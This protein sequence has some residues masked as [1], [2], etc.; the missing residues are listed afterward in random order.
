MAQV[1]DGAGGYSG[2]DWW[3]STVPEMWAALEREEVTDS[4]HQVQSGWQATYN[5]IANHLERVKDYKTKL[6][7]AWPPEKSPA[8]AAYVERLDALI[9][10]L[11]DTY[12]AATTNHDAFKNAMLAVSSRRDELKRLYEEYAA[13]EAKIAEFTA[14]KERLGNTGAADAMQ[15]EVTPRHQQQLQYRAARIMVGLTSELSEANSILTRPKPYMPNAARNEGAEIGDGTGYFVP[16]FAAGGDHA[17]S[18]TSAAEAHPR[19]SSLE[20][21]DRPPFSR[22]HP[23]VV[24]E[25]ATTHPVAP[26]PTPTSQPSVSPTPGGGFGPGAPPG[27]GLGPQGRPP[28]DPG[29]MPAPGSTAPLGRRPTSTAAN[30]GGFPRGGMGGVIG[31]LPGVPGQRSD[32]GRTP[33]RINPIGGVIGGPNGGVTGGATGSGTRTGSTGVSGAA[34][35]G[36]GFGPMGGRPVSDRD[37]AGGTPRWEPD[38]PWETA[39]GVTPVL[40]PVEEQRI[41]PGPAIG[42]DR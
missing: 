6:T 25:G 33:Q 8:A 5:T 40:G 17:P 13:N 35:P 24:I 7:A 19:P 16:P 32:G 42:L 39:E 20:S 28:A 2:T 36:A 38:N 29:R 12:N 15:P 18:R 14:A 31:G 4:H 26:G 22:P 23:G 37:Q 34:M 10:H 21:H 1:A 27:P 11:Q 41:D 9:D 30:G 3:N